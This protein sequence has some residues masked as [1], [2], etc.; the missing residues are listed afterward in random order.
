[1]EKTA[2]KENG[3]ED[4]EN[5]LEDSEKPTARPGRSNSIMAA[6]TR[7]IGE[8]APEFAPKVEEVPIDWDFWEAVVNDAAKVYAERPEEL[9]QAV[10]AGIPPT[11]RGVVWQSLSDSKSSELEAIYREVIAL[12]ADATAEQAR[13]LFGSYWLW[14]PSPTPSSASSPRVT[15]AMTPKSDTR[16]TGLE[17]EMQWGKTVSQLEK[18]IKRDLGDRTSFGKYK[19]DQK[20]LLN[21]C[22]AYALFDPAVGYTQGMTFIVTVLLLNVSIN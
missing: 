15:P 20:A 11:L 5:K 14:D 21:V 12:P 1:M 10:Q 8:P 22:K 7:M 17:K 18:V 4:A 9:N 3:D 13:P 19:A 16:F 2:V 6:M